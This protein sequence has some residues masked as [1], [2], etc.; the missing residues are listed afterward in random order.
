MVVKKCRRM[1]RTEG[2]KDKRIGIGIT[3]VAASWKAFAC[4]KR[5]I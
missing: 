3:V 5:L 2:D 4:N 1:G